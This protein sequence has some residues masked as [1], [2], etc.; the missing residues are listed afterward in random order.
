MDFSSHTVQ[1]D[2][3]PRFSAQRPIFHSLSRPST[4]S[5]MPS[6]RKITPPED[7]HRRVMGHKKLSPIYAST[8]VICP[9]TP[10]ESFA[11]LGP[12]DISRYEAM[13]QESIRARKERRKWT[14]TPLHEVERVQ[15]SCNGFDKLYQA[16][17]G[18]ELGFRSVSSEPEMIFVVIDIIPFQMAIDYVQLSN[19]DRDH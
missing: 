1:E 14:F 13:F 10:P 11:A 8:M 12:T 6:P 3:S 7:E 2:F 16:L 17:G 4:T 19:F 5:N 15:I 18:G 9:P